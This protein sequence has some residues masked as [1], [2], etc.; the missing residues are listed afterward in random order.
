M[1]A[2]LK[3]HLAVFASVL[4]LSPLAANADTK[5]FPCG[6]WSG[7]FSSVV[8]AWAASRV[9]DQSIWKRG[10]SLNESFNRAVSRA[11]FPVEALES[12]KCR[13]H[14]VTF[15]K[16]LLDLYISDPRR[17]ANATR[18]I[19]GVEGLRERIRQLDLVH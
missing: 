15:L 14:I 7:R 5:P 11:W 16:D 18:Q 4:C 19:N 13:A 9:C 12:P 8:V 3:L 10:H 2:R 17:C 6:A 1:A